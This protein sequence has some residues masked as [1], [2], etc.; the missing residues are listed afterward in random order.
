MAMDHPDHVDGLV[1]IAPAAR[2]WV[3]DAAWY[4]HL[5]HTPLLGTVMTRI[6]VPTYGRSRLDEGVASTFAPDPVPENY[7]EDTALPL[8]LRA[9][10]WK[11]NTWD[12][13]QVNRS[14][15]EQE[16]R[17]HEIDVPAVLIAGTDDTV[18]LT[19]RHSVPVSETMPNAEL[20][21][22]EG[23]G[24]NPHHAHTELVVGAIGTVLERADR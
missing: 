8:I 19:Q 3:G 21:L 14:L 24:H 5:T 17:Y 10:A 20:I 23:S 15:A 18:L 7:S 22:L 1:L 11:A 12:L 2:A 6:I 13:S 4:N 9:S 16:V